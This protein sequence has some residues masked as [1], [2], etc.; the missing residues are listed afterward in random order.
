MDFIVI[1]WEHSEANTHKSMGPASGMQWG[2]NEI[3]ATYYYHYCLYAKYEFSG[4]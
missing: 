1:S 3:L 4:R 2:I